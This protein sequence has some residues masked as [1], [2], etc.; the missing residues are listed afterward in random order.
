MDLRPTAAIMIPGA[1]GRQTRDIA[2]GFIPSAVLDVPMPYPDCQRPTVSL[3]PVVFAAL[4][5]GS[6]M[7]SPT[8]SQTRLTFVGELRD[9]TAKQ[10]CS[11]SWRPTATCQASHAYGCGRIVAWVE[12][13]R[14]RNRALL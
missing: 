8:D 11:L 12:S 5:S 3:V 2:D 9:W 14:K 7:P 13:Y 4:L 10:R 6:V 1:A